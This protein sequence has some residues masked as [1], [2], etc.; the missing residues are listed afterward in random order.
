MWYFVGIPTQMKY[1]KAFLIFWLMPLALWGQDKASLAFLEP[2]DTFHAQRFWICAGTGAAIYTAASIGLY[3]AWYK[4]YERTSFQTFN[5][6]G[7]WKD[8]DKAGHLVTAY[9]ESKY[10]FDGLLWT[11]TSRRKSMWMAAGVGILLQ[12]TVEL[13]DAHSAK[14]GFSWADTGFNLLGVAG[15]VGQEMAWQEQRILF[16][17]S[18]TPPDYPDLLIAPDGEGPPQSIRS[19]ANQLYGSSFAEKALKDYN[20]Q[21]LWASANIASFYGHSKPD[22][23][24]SWLN[25]ATGYGAQNLLGGFSNTWQDE[26]TGLAYTVPEGTYPRYRQFY[27]SLDADL[28]RIPTNKRWLRLVLSTLNWIKIPAPTLEYNTRGKLVFHPVYW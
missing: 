16:K 20:G 1:N 21:T 5:D 18:N 4:D 11:G 17:I 14:W 24:P 9:N 28:S 12:S 25:I 8:I 2:A 7:E 13:M 10:S 26:S 6:W 19:R 23:L 22:W 27:L 15:F 3:Q